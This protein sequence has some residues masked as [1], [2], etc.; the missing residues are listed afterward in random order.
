MSGASGVSAAADAIAGGAI[1]RSPS[2]S[3]A[4]AAADATAAAADG[5]AAARAADTACCRPFAVA[6]LHVLSYCDRCIGKDI[7]LLV[8]ITSD[9]LTQRTQLTHHPHATLDFVSFSWLGQLQVTV[10]PPH[11]EQN[12]SKPYYHVVAR[13]HT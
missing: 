6:H 2:S 9:D 10:P 1:A 5:G 4:G 7:F 8:E 11:S 3:S 12:I 13:F